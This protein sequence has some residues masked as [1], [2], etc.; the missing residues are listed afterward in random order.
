VRSWWQCERCE[1]TWVP[2][3]WDAEPRVCPKCKSPYWNKPRRKP[4]NVQDR[5]TDR[6]LVFT[7]APAGTRIRNLSTRR[8]LLFPFEL[9][10]LVG[11]EGVGVSIRPSRGH[12][13]LQ[14]CDSKRNESRLWATRAET[15]GISRAIGG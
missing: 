12:T 5:V 11:S 14:R 8:E 1:H 6:V 2:R 4:K 13:Y 7:S 9:R 3:D 15:C 10:A